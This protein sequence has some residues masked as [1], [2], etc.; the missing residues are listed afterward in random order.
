MFADE[1]ERARR[2]RAFDQVVESIASRIRAGELRPGDRLPPER[3]LAR[4]LGMS[5]LSIRSGL[6]YLAAMGV[7]R[8]RHG[9]GSEIRQK[10]ELD[11]R[12]LNLLSAL[13]GFTQAQV[14]EARRVLEPACAGLA[15]KRATTEQMTSMADEVTEMFASID[16]PESFR[17]HNR[18]FHHAVA[19]SSGNPVLAALLGLISSLTFEQELSAS[20]QPCALHE[21]AGVYRR[22]YLAV[23]AHDAESADLEMA[24]HLRS[25]LSDAHIEG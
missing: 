6:Q 9:V 8:T 24:L 21:M 3:V 4:D 19:T 14:L 17:Y 13:H 2:W 16:H 7:L 12:A 23:R 25:L 1:R 20:G 22:I 10:P 15:A 5:R 18:C 11:S